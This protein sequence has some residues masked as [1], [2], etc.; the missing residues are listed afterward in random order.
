MEK[1]N[2]I[3]AYCNAVNMSYDELPNV[4]G[5]GA[6]FSHAQSA[7]ATNPTPGVYDFELDQIYD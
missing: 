6:E 5:G 7:Q 3:L 4:S 2:R 1:P